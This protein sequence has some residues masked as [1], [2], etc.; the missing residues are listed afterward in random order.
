MKNEFG[1]FDYYVQDHIRLINRVTK[2][3]KRLGLSPWQRAV[4]SSFVNRAYCMGGDFAGAMMFQ[5]LKKEREKNKAG[6]N[7][8]IITIERK[9]NKIIEIKVQPGKLSSNELLEVAEHLKQYL[10]EKSN[11]NINR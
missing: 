5:D 3:L 2:Y 6:K 10:N 9:E 7:K 4:I 11:S 8:A 1:T